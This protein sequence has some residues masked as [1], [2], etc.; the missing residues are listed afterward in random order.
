VLLL[1]RYVTLITL[2]LI[3]IVVPVVV[4]LFTFVVVRCYV[5]VVVVCVV[6][7][8]R[9]VV[10]C[11]ALT[12]HVVCYVVVCSR[13]TLLLIVVTRLRCYLALLLF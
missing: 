11:Y 7:V 9:F 13:F 6:V 10:D 1:L 4:T 5:V 3:T 12:P 2:R 8:A